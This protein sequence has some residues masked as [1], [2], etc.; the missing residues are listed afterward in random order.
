M[1]RYIYIAMMNTAVLAVTE[2]FKINPSSHSYS[3]VLI[4][5]KPN[6]DMAKSYVSRDMISLQEVRQVDGEIDV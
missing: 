1:K 2:K 5:P 6:N 4:F 3:I